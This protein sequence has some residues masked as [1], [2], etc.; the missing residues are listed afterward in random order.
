MQIIRKKAKINLFYNKWPE[1]EELLQN[2]G[3]SVGTE[4]S[5]LQHCH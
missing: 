4:L 2:C 3:A 5:A 1:Q